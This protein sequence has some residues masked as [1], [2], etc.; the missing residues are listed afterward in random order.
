MR[1]TL[2]VATTN[3]GKL[4][5]LRAMLED[6]PVTV[7]C[8][9]D[10]MRKPIEVIE[11]GKTFADNA[12][13]KARTIAQATTCLTLADDSG[14]EV[15]VLNGA[16]GVRSAR[17]AHERATDAENNA[18]LVAALDAIAPAESESETER[19]KARFRCVLALIDPFA[20]NEPH[21]VEG[22]CEGSITR[23]PRGSFGFGYDPMFVVSDD[24]A[25]RTMA[26][27]PDAE[28]N[29]ISHRARMA[30]AE[31]RDREIARRARR[32]DPENPRVA[33]TPRAPSA[34]CLRAER[35]APSVYAP[36][37]ERQAPSVYASSCARNSDDCIGFENIGKSYFS[38]FLCSSGDVAA[39][40]S[41]S[42]MTSKP[43][44]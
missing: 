37:A 43:C 27:L 41:V 7:V 26:E 19:P 18:A 34:E 6:L 21:V 20:D 2:V 33:P 23:Y 44:S 25:G 4:K 16:P 22:A 11:D 5:E 38:A 12:I 8:T 28:K 15:D 9:E 13:K 30:E 17:F 31:A 40:Q 29:R 39:A 36:S 35:R 24:P 42:V 10:V 3:K 14:L 1:H 32:A